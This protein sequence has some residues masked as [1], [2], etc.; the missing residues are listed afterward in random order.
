MNYRPIPV[1]PTLAKITERPL[2]QQMLEHVE[3]HKIINKNQFGFLKNKSSNDT[4]IS[5]TVAINQ[6]VEQNETLIGIFLDLAKAFSSISHKNF[7][8]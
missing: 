1:T 4:V 8:V 7:K 2:L 5:L 3:E 6:L